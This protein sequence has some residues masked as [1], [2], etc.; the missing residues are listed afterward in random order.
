MEINRINPRTEPL[1]I[2]YHRNQNKE[3]INIEDLYQ[4]VRGTE[5]EKFVEKFYHSLKNSDLNK[6]MIINEQEFVEAIHKYVRSFYPCCKV[7]ISGQ[8]DIQKSKEIYLNSLLQLMEKYNVR[9][10]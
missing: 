6:D 1:R 7:V 8:Y 2:E 5:D 9:N 3:Y 10:Y 4:K